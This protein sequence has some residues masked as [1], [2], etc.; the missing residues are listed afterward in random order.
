M[1][2]GLISVDRWTQGSQVYFLTHLHSDH[3]QGL[4]ST[5]ARGPLFCSRLTAKLLPFKF[6]DLNLSLLRVLEIDSWQYV[7]LIS[8]SSGDKTIVEVMAID[9]H[10]CP[11]AIM[12]LF[13][14]EFGCLLYTGDFRWETSSE[15][16]KAGRTTLIEALKDD[17]VD[18][19]YMDNT[20]CNPSFAFPSRQVAAQQVVDIIASHPN[21]DI[22]I[23]IDSL[24]KEELLLHISCVFNIKIWVWPERLQTM[25]LLGFH[26]IFT[27]KTSLTR[28]RA[29]PRYSFSIDT[30]EGLNMIRPTIGIMPSGL[31]WV[32]RPHKRDDNLFGSLLTSRY[33]RS[34][35]SDGDK[36]NDN[37]GSVERFHKY[38]YSVPYSDHSCFMEIEEFIKLV[39]PTNIKGIVSSSSCYVD[40]LYYFG[41]LCAGNQPSLRLHYRPERKVEGKRSV[42]VPTK[43]NIVSSNFTE[44]NRKRKRAAKLN[45]LGFHASKVNA[46]RRVQR[47]A[48]IAQSECSC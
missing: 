40:P 46:L 20:F 19:L 36:P 33:N 17:V 1:E 22:I 42:A 47:G 10:H 44:T 29:V 26:D 43:S 8:P 24:G 31:P 28:V 34:K 12:L 7:S 11:G 5:W 30:L 15:R 2:I 35:W 48:K 3:T 4:S 32:V 38:I 45:F 9:A 18:I 39:Q 23:G 21:H 16:A 13:R 37:L 14:G 6:P 25:H 41:R 27:T